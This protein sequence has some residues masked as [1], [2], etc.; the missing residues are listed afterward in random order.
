MCR[1]GGFLATFRGFAMPPNCHFALGVAM[2]ITSGTGYD[3]TL[4]ENCDFPSTPVCRGVPLASA[5]GNRA[6]MISSAAR[7][8]IPGGC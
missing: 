5:S 1:A 8:I 3:S 7:E 2:S 4:R 6:V